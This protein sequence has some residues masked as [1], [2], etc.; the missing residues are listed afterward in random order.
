MCQLVSAGLLGC[1]V[2]AMVA[3]SSAGS[4]SCRPVPPCRRASLTPASWTAHTHTR[5]PTHTHK[6]AQKRCKWTVCFYS[7]KGQNMHNANSNPRRWAQTNTARRRKAQS[8][9]IQIL[10]LLLQP[11]VHRFL[12]NVTGPGAAGICIRRAGKPLSTQFHI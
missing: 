4:S 7:K 6:K 5:T 3:L 1:P 10:K 8:C 9:L 2:A 11:A 12:I